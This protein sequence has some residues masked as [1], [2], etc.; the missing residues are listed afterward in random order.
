[1][2][3]GPASQT[4]TIL[5]VDDSEVVLTVAKTS[6]EAAGYRVLTH[7]GPA[8]CVAVILQE[9]P[10]LVLIDV[11][12][13]KLGGETIVKLF[14]KA[15]PDSKTIILLFSTLPAESLEEKAAA[16]GA[17]GFVRKTDD[18]YDLVRQVNRWLRDGGP[19]AR[20]SLLEPAA[21]SAR[22][23]PR[24]PS[25]RPVAGTTTSA[26]TRHASRPPP[27]MSGTTRRL[28]LVLFIDANID[29]LSSFRRS[30]QGEPYAAD[31]AL[32]PKQALLHIDSDTPPDVVVARLRS[33]VL[34]VYTTAVTSDPTWRR[35]FVFVRSSSLDE[36]SQR[37]L[38]EFEGIVMSE[39]VDGATLRE[40]IRG[41]LATRGAAST[42][43]HQS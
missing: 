20:V 30:V 37:F 28:P 7:P 34:E 13:P 6:L 16:S 21:G 41:L 19:S 35:R 11:N 14:G 43:A 38:A 40:G 17:H 29:V 36:R 12:M 9:K 2:A 42:G 10:D 27:R 32:S 31:F 18:R 5:V 26:A 3:R 39:P 8:G 15:Q 33:N 4:P 1:M 24:R 25:N 22:G 23:E